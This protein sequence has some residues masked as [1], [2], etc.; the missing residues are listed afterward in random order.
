MI[1]SGT[2]VSLEKY[3]AL[4]CDGVPGPPVPEE[5]VAAF[6]FT[7]AM[8]SFRSFAG[9]EVFETMICGLAATIPTGSKSP[10]TSYDGVCTAPAITWVPTWPIAPVQPSGAEC[11]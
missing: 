3:T 5:T 7:H 1:G 8:N 6:A 4:T 11:A 10:N 9:T 2:P